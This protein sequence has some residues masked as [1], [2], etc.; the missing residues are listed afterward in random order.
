MRF[1]GVSGWSVSGNFDGNIDGNIDGESS[2]LI[3]YEVMR[4]VLACLGNTG[5]KAG[6]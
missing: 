4:Y 1:I 2:E 6:E 5:D 3:V